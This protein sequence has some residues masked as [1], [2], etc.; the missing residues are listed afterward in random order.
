VGLLRAW[1]INRP[2]KTAVAAA[3]SSDHQ[4]AGLYLADD[5]T[6]V[7]WAR[8]KLTQ[9]K[10]SEFQPYRSALLPLACYQGSGSCWTWTGLPPSF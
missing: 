10:P 7:S 8:S 5:V 2:A 4:P 1:E 9:H 6:L 3:C